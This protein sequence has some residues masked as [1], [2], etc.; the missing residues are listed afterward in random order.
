MQ[1]QKKLRGGLR[2]E[3]RGWRLKQLRST[4]K[5][6]APCRMHLQKK[7]RGAL[8]GATRGTPRIP[9]SLLRYRTAAPQK[10]LHSANCSRPK[11]CI[12]SRSCQP[13]HMTQ[14]FY[15]ALV[16]CSKFK[17][18]YYQRKYSLKTLNKFFVIL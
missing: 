4:A 2:G 18:V 1:L 7:L 3:K 8:R 16:G 11:I 12:R 5:S 15:L 6:I 14:W 17:N 10:Q 9:T 13:F